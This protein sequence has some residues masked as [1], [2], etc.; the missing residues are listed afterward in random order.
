[1]LCLRCHKEATE[2]S[3]RQA[4]ERMLGAMMSPTS[5]A[6]KMAQG[7]MSN[8]NHVKGLHCNKAGGCGHFELFI[9]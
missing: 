8:Q 5:A 2:L 9:T 7:S 4:S 1:M 3:G 6:Y